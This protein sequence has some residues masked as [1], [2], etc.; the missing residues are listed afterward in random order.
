M[1]LVRFHNASQSAKFIKGSNMVFSPV[2]GSDN[3]NTF[4]T[5]LLYSQNQSMD[6]GMPAEMGVVGW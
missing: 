5:Q 3:T 6:L 2:T 1:S 4:F